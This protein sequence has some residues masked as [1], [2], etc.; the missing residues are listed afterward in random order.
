MKP[1]DVHL[2]RG[3]KAIVIAFGIWAARGKDGWVHIHMTGDN[4]NF[5][6]I[7]VVNNPDSK[8]RYNRVLFRDL[9]RLL[10]AQ[11]KWPFGAE[12]SET[13]NR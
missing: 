10:I 7:T 12:G 11:G 8:T 3:N 5:K 2:F 13:E 4:K 1:G 9:R 6:H